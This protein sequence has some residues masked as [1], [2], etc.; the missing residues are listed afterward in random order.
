MCA[1]SSNDTERKNNLKEKKMYVLF[2]TKPKKNIQT[3]QKSP[4]S[5]KKGNLVMQF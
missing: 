1:D 2:T 4:I 3:P 5:K